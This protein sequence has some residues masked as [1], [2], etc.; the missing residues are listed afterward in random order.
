[1]H[2]LYA[3]CTHEGAARGMVKTVHLS[4]P[5]TDQERATTRRSLGPAIYPGR[6]SVIRRL[7]AGEYAQSAT[8]L[9]TG[10]IDE[11]LESYLSQS[12]QIP[13]LIV[14]DVV[15]DANGEIERSAGVMI[16]ALPD[17]D[18]ALLEQF[19]AQLRDGGLAR[20]LPGID[21]AEALLSHVSRDAEQVQKSSV[22]YQ[23][24]CSRD[25]VLASLH[26]FDVRDLAEMAGA[27]ENVEVG[28]DLC[29]RKYTVTP[30]D[31]VRAFETL[32]KAQG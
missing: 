9:A 17:G 8:P 31:L 30:E 32:V 16:Q 7:A 5:L 23:C 26:M 28:C 14:C 3:D 24:R 19:R 12:E 1:M 20:A 18:R 27:N 22:R 25:R 29:G 15:L 11:D 10:E 2:G 6:I 4:F 13:T 21:S